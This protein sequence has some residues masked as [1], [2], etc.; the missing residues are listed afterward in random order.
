MRWHSIQNKVA[1]YE[2]EEIYWQLR[3]LNERISSI[4][5][6]LSHKVNPNMYT[7]SVNDVAV[8]RKKQ[9]LHVYTLS[10]LSVLIVAELCS[11]RS[12]KSHNDSGKKITTRVLVIQRLNLK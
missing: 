2:N 8:V 7:I 4:L 3:S 11:W 6:G 9:I 5:I 12:V 10:Y 1:C